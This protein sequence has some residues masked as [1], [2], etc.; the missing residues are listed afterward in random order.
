MALL[1]SGHSGGV[2][3]HPPPKELGKQ[4][5]KVLPDLLGPTH[6]TV[7][8]L[9]P[10]VPVGSHLYSQF[11]ALGAGLGLGT[12]AELGAKVRGFEG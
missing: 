9:S 1:Q 7:Q 2:P 6:L 11:L 3:E 5:P 10:L 8:P 4:L 12:G